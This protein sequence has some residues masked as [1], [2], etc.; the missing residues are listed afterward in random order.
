MHTDQFSLRSDLEMIKDIGE[1]QQHVLLCCSQESRG[2]DEVNPMTV[3]EDDAN[4]QSSDI[5]E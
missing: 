5:S 3:R 2:A 1:G 4:P